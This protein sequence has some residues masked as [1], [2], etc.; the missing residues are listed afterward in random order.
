MFQ[1]ANKYNSDQSP[2]NLD[3]LLQTII[4]SYFF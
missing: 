4:I 3:F 1:L 2:N